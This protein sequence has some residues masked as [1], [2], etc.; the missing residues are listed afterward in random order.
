MQRGLRYLGLVY[1]EAMGQGCIPIGSKGEGIDGVIKDSE[2]GFLCDPDDEKALADIIETIY[3][4][5]R[6]QRAVI[7]QKAY[8]TVRDMTSRNMAIRYL[9]SIAK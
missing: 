8:D 4:M 6:G 7:A 9:D 1:L 3:K 5:P 2:N